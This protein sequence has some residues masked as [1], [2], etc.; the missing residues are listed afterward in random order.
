[1]ALAL[2]WYGLG[3][4]GQQAAVRIDEEQEVAW[5]GWNHDQDDQASDSDTNDEPQPDQSAE[6]K[7]KREAERKGKQRASK[8][9]AKLRAAGTLRPLPFRLVIVKMTVP[10]AFA[11]P[12]GVIGITPPL[13]KQLKTER[14]LA[15]V[16]A[17]E[18]GHHQHRHTLKNLGRTLFQSIAMATMGLGDV[19]LMDSAAGLAASSYSRA[20]EREA[21]EFALRLVYRAYGS[22]EDTLEFFEWARGAHETKAS[23][24]TGW[25]GSHPLS[26]DRIAYLKNLAAEL[27]EK[28]KPQHR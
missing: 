14:G 16:L 6:A 13:L 28:T 15:M 1:M 18:L 23:K 9:L 17:H 25:A 21:D 3:W 5:F 24:L 19:P 26:S 7:E 10:N 12:G 2:T 8:I 22:T 27:D 11:F 4:L 20:H